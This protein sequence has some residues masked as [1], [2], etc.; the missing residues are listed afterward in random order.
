[1][2]LIFVIRNGFIYEVQTGLTIVTESPAARRGFSCLSKLHQLNGQED[3]YVIGKKYALNDM[4]NSLILLI[5]KALKMLCNFTK[6]W[7][8]QKKNK[9]LNIVLFFSPSYI[10]GNSETDIVEKYDVKNKQFVTLPERI[11]VG[12]SRSTCASVP[13]NYIR[14]L[15]YHCA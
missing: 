1:M 14:H 3:I 6:F 8:Q 13:K 7:L 2:F 5:L 11:L 15:G 12:R 4:S 10:G 9:R